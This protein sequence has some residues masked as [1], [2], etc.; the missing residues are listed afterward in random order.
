MT[1]IPRIGLCLASMLAAAQPVAAQD[2]GTSAG[3]HQA[4]GAS[5]SPVSPYAGM[6]K[7]RIKALSAEQ[8]ADLEAGRGMSLALA[9]ELNGYPGPLHVLELADALELEQEQRTRARELLDAMRAETVP[10]GARI[11]AEEAAL[12][13]LFAER[14]AIRPLVAAA[15]A[16]IGAANGTLRAAHLGYHLAMMEILTPGQVARYAELRGYAATGAG[17][18]TR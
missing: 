7:R 15:T 8:A 17:R 9:A 2:H 4:T 3:R 18:A 6:E 12:D 13:R 14:R 5:R 10:I 1:A 11:V 16:R